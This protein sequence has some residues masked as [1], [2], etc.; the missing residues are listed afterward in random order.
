MAAASTLL[1]IH[2]GPVQLNL[3]KENAT[4]NIRQLPALGDGY[5]DPPDGGW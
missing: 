2:R 1:C 4:F 5:G 3:L